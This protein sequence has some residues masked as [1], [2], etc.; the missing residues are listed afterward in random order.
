MK[1]IGEIPSVCVS[2]VISMDMSEGDFTPRSI[3]HIQENEADW[4]SG[5]L[6]ENKESDSYVKVK[7]NFHLL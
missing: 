7:G 2:L 5:I 6:Q 3:W 4:R 1:E